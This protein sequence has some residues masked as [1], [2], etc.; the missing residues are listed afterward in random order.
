MGV[1]LQIR[2]QVDRLALKIEEYVQGTASGVWALVDAAVDETYENRVK[3]SD[4]TAMDDALDI[5]KVGDASKVR[6]WFTLHAAYA[7]DDLGLTNPAFVNLI[8]S[9][10]WR[11]PQN[12]FRNI[13]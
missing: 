11:V 7:V 12:E 13:G 10:G 1:E 8:K 3:G 6:P 4:I 5:G 9:Y 2:K